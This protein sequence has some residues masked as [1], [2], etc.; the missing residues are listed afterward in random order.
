MVLQKTDTKTNGTEDPDINSCRYSQLI[1]DKEAQNIWWRKD[2]LFNEW[3]WENWISTCRLLKLD[4]C[5]SPYTKRHSKWIKDFN[6]RP[7]TL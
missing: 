3:S 6:I 1:F 5:L 7:K 2:S 4:P